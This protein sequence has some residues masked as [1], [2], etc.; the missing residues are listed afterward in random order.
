GLSEQGGKRVLR[1][2]EADLK[3]RNRCPRALKQLPRLGDVHFRRSAIT[4]AHI[5]DA[6]R[7]FLHT[8]VLT[9]FLDQLFEGANTHIAARDFSAERDER[10]LVVSHGAHISGALRL[11]VFAVLAPEVR[12]PRCVKTKLLG[13]VITSE[14]RRFV[15]RVPAE[16]DAA[17]ACGY[18]LALRILIADGDTEYGASFHDP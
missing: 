8:H 2:S 15:D 7:F 4:E 6:Q 13:P 11:D 17:D 18:L 10:V 1:L 9:A 5:R 14:V 16:T 3:L 12:F